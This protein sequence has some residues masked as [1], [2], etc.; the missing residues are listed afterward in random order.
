[1]TRVKL[2][3]QHLHIT[4]AKSYNFFFSYLITQIIIPGKKY[5]I[6]VEV[7]DQQFVGLQI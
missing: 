1:M 7:M 5:L 2:Q 4:R 6:V 3:R